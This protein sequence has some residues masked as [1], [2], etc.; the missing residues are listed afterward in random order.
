MDPLVKNALSRA[1]K[2]TFKSLPQEKGSLYF[3]SNQSFSAL[4][5]FFNDATCQIPRLKFPPGLPLT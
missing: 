1:G 2:Y 3:P 4:V 5:R